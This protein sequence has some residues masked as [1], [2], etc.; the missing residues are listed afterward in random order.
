VPLGSGIAEDD[1]LFHD[2]RASNA[3]LAFLLAQMR[4]PEFPEPI[5]VFRNVER[6]I[7]EELVEM[8]LK[9]AQTKEGAGDLES[10]FNTGDTWT[11]N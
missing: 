8:H 2:E 4:H 9:N 7:Y 6:P 1:L 10:L 11:V 5:G 3:T